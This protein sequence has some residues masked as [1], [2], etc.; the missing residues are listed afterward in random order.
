MLFPGKK[1]IMS[2]LPVANILL[3]DDDPRSLLAMETLLAGPGR[4][5]VRAQTGNEALRCL[6]R[7]EFA[8]IL[9]DVRLPDMDGFETASL[10]RGTE[11]L[12]RIPIIF[13]SAIDTLEEDVFKGTSSGAV[14]YL[15]KPVV[16]QVLQ[17][18]VSV[19]IDLYHMAE[20][21]KRRAVHHSEERLRVLLE[22]VRD[23]A[24]FLL[25]GRGVIKICN[26]VAE[27]IY[28]WRTADLVGQPISVFFNAEDREAGKPRQV[29]SAAASAAFHQEQS[30]CVR[31]DGSAFWAEVNYACVKDEAGGLA[32]F[33]AVARDLT[34]ATRAQRELE[35]LKAELEE[36]VERLVTERL[37]AMAKRETPNQPP[38]QSQSAVAGAPSTDAAELVAETNASPTLAPPA[39]RRTILFADDEENQI[40]LMRRFLESEGYKVSAAKDGAEALEVF[41]KDR[42]AIDLAI[43]DVR[44]PKLNGWDA[45]KQM[46]EARPEIKAIFATGLVSPEMEA[47]VA[48]QK[49]G[50]VIRKPYR[51]DIVLE[52]I[53]EVLRQGTGA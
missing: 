25:D 16:P 15:F 8:L 32:G 29:L 21:L 10:I 50:S 26:S 46:R 13:I 11:R 31:R 24:I 30:W 12:R 34:E 23:H 2:G 14:D 19:F 33:C 18:K 42:D 1:L 47:E 45:F 3:V 41:L 36:R 20:Q 38:H 49:L 52:K 53:A 37:R 43:L 4:R 27:R 35:R 5:I 48:S 40:Q 6:L 44:L 28:G 22:S 17:G 51:L 9:L 7:E 39:G